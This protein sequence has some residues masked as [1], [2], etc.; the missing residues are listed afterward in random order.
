MFSI[1]DVAQSGRASALGAESRWFK[2]SLPDQLIMERWLSL[3]YGASLENWRSFIA[4]V[5]S[6][7]TLSAILGRWLRGLK[8]LTANEAMEIVNFVRGF[9][10]H[11]SRHA[12]KRE[13][14]I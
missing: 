1:R 6:N 8:H 4:S 7:P 14:R 13:E 9:E 10:P 5:G 12:K 11:S 3:V 2:S